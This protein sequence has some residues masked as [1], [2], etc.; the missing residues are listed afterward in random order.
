MSRCLP[1]LMYHH[2]NPVGNFINVTPERF[3]AQMRY[4]SVHGY[5]SLTIDDLKR[6]SPGQDGISQR[7]VMITFDDGWLDNWLYAFP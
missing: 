7:S 2:V 5:K 3:E 4:L 6:M 1:I